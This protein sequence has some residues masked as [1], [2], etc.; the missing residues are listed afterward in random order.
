MSTV[1]SAR[2]MTKRSPE[3]IEIRHARACRTRSGD[4]CNCRPSYRAHVWSERDRKR[5]RKT[6]A[7]RAAAK[8][9]RTDALRA[10][11]RGEMRAPSPLTLQ[12]VA[13]AWLE[14]AR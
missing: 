3:G 9:W 11:R 2:T 7:S 1:G 8:A 10:L 12:Q 4:P 13:E 6:F 5:I 14:G